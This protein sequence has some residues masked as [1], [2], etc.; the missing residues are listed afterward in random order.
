MDLWFRRIVGWSIR[1]TME[2]SLVQQ[3]FDHALQQRKPDPGLLH[4]ADQGSQYTAN[5][6]RG[7]LRLRRIVESN[8]RKGNVWDNAVMES[9]FSSVEMELLRLKPFKTQAEAIQE[10]F[11]YIEVFYNRQRIHSTLG[12]CSPVEFEQSYTN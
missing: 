9:F 3:G 7:Q 5:G 2:E 12:G 10:V 8:S 6:F 4:H 11:S 1:E